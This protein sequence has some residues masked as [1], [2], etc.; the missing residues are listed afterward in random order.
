LHDDESTHPDYASLV[1]PLFACGGKRGRN[2]NLLNPSLPLAEERV[3][4][5]S[6]VPIAIGRVSK[7]TSGIN[8]NPMTNDSMTRSK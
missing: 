4:E 8:A 3:V 6:V 7:Y 1:D 5:R 2:V